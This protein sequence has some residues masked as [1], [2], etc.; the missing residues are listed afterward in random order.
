MRATLIAVMSSMSLSAGV[1]FAA[2]APP[3][4]QLAPA[5]MAVAEAQHFPESGGGSQ[6]ICL[7]HVHEG[8]M[9][10]KADCRTKDAWDKARR[11]NTET[12][13][14]FQLRSLTVN[15]H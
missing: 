9:M 2:D 3:P 12:I 6:V 8:V 4:V 10:R 7:H 13:S 11:E 14:E 1:A 15:R 5:P